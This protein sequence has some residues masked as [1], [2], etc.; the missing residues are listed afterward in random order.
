MLSLAA[1]AASF[2]KWMQATG[3]PPGLLGACVLRAAD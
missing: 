3:V 1:Q 2:N